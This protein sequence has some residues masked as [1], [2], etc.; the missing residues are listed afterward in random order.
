L[1]PETTQATHCLTRNE[2]Q[3]KSEKN[4]D[5]IISLIGLKENLSQNLELLKRIETDPETMLTDGQITKLL[6][7]LAQLEDTLLKIRWT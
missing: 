7:L 3:L 6:N 5:T 2:F 1:I 4:E